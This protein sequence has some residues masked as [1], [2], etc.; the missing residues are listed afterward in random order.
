MYG[1]M[2]SDKLKVNNNFTSPTST[3]SVV[4]QNTQFCN[5]VN[6]LNP[7]IP[8]LLQYKPIAKGDSGATRTYLTPEHATLLQNTQ[9]NDNIEVV[10][11]NNDT[12]KS[13]TSGELNI[14]ELSTMGRQAYV[15]NGL[16]NSLISLGQLADD[17]C[18]II[19]TKKE[20]QVFK[21]Y[22]KILHGFRNNN[23]GL[24]DIPLPNSPLSLK[25]KNHMANVIIHKK[26]NIN[27]LMQYFHATLYSPTKSTL[28][29]A[30][31]NGNFIGWPGLTSNNITKHLQETEHTAKGHLDQ[32]RKNLQS[33][34]NQQV[35]D[36]DF[37]PIQIA[38]I[39]NETIAFIIDPKQLKKGF[40]DLTGRFPY[41]SSRGN[42]Y[43]FVLYDFDSNAILSTPLKSRLAGEIKNAWERLHDKLRARGIEPNTY[44]MDNE[45]SKELK[46]AILKYKLK[47]QLTP[48]HMHR[49]N[50]AERAIRTF[51]NHFIA[52]LSSVDPTFP[53]GEWDRLLDQAEITLNLLRNS[54]V[55]NKLSAYA[56]LHGVYDFNKSPMA[57]P[58]TK[59]VAHVKT[60]VRSSFGFHGTSG[61][62]IAPTL[63]HY[64]CVQCYI[65]ST[66]Q[67]LIEDTVQFFPHK[68]KFPSVSINDHLLNAI[69][70]IISILHNK[71]F[72][73]ENTTI[74]FHDETKVALQLVAD[75]LHAVT[76]KPVLPPPSPFLHQVK[77]T[78]KN[79]VHLPILKI[80]HYM[81]IKILI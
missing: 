55:N 77:A 57:P 72:Q 35:V 7:N 75:I 6:N 31:K 33:T 71:K 11:P 19:L 67:V 44:I 50:A 65:P 76:K 63:E 81:I 61:F 8:P 26:Q 51:K 25:P 18:T 62:Y 30:V 37:H 10:L 56:Y 5:L 4:Q 27:D 64:R 66:R 21:S 78:L 15:L 68:I 69:D 52:G 29:K 3:S 46:R 39:T 14:P 80:S 2:N 28:L 47:Y 73:H 36:H 23:D 9:R 40:F 59:V 17:N 60:K 12:L 22:K 49:I 70:D 45:A 38:Q 43:I 53:I 16:N 79:V 48:P 20:L 34:I 42:N 41:T 58:G 54:R 32:H 1:R 74:Q 13:T 24:W